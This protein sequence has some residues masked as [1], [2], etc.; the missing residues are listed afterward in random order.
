M[1]DVAAAP[2]AIDAPQR[3]LWSDVWFQFRHH[4]GAM[5]GVVIFAVIV[6]LV[7]VRARGS[8]GRPVATST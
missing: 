6:F 1:T 3:S 5:V 7:V 8:G 4:R 2:A